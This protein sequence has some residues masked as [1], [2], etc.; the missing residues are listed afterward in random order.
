M[1]SSTRLLVLA[2]LLVGIGSLRSHAQDK[3]FGIG[4]IVGEPTGISGKAWVSERNAVDFGL[5][6]SF[7]NS[8]YLHL[9]ADYLWHFPDAIEAR[10]RFVVY[11]GIGGRLGMPEDKGVFGARLPVGIAWW[12]RSIPLDVFLEIAPILD[13]VPATKFLVHGGIGARYFFP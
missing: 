3:G 10:E 8:G 2:I 7:G 6:W 11:A 13:L 9:H 12:P 4:L 1:L 5:A